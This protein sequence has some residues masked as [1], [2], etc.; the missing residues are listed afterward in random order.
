MPSVG[1]RAPGELGMWEMGSHAEE[2]EK[3]RGVSVRLL[4]CFGAKCSDLG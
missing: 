4:R 3:G 2:W 1:A